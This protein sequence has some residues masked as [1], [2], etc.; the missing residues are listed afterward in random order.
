MLRS[1][2]SCGRKFAQF[3]FNEDSRTT[4]N[5]ARA[6]VDLLPYMDDVCREALR[7]IPSI[8]MT[9][10]ESL[11]DDVIGGYHVPAGT[12]IYILA[13]AINRLTSFWGPTA[14]EFDPSRWRELPNTNVP[15]AFMT[16]LAGPRGCIG[17]KFAE[18]EMKTLL[19]C[20]LSKF[21]FEMDT[22]VP[23]PGMYLLRL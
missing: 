1:R 11:K 9:V 10:R 4:H 8:P 13:N 22:T 15:N 17:R 3:L 2:P 6:D 7:F 20:L 12:T 5:A 21:S 16:F 23:D 14:N 18:I 19:C